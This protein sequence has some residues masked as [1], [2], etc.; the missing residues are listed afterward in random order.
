[1]RPNDGRRSTTRRTAHD[2]CQSIENDREALTRA[3][4][5]HGVKVEPARYAPD[6]L[7]VKSGNPLRTP[8][9]GSGLF[10]LQDEASQLVSLLGAPRPGMR[11]LDTCASP[12]G[13]TTAMAAM[14]GDR[15]SRSSPPTCGTRACSCCGK[16]STPAAHE[17]FACVQA[18][19]ESRPALRARIRRRV[20]RRALFGPRHGAAGPRHSLAP[21][22]S[23]SRRRS[24][25]RS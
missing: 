16:P 23:R 10:F 25:A 20:R 15:R 1:M 3:L 22:R 12:G 7:M 17:T 24:R 2:S 13:K 11:V 5:E 14:A 9:A 8:L 18:D 6:G 4:A 21:D 19:L